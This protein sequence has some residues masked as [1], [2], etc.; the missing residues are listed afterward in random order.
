MLLIYILLKNRTCIKERRH[1]QNSA[2]VSHQVSPA[3]LLDVS[4]YNCRRALVDESEIIGNQM[5]MHDRS[6]MDTVQGSPCSP[7]PW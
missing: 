3:L 7:T 5:A 1:R 2:T 4:A 6:E